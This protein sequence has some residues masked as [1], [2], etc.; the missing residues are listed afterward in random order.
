[1]T[2]ADFVQSR[3]KNGT[4]LLFDGCKSDSPEL[5]F[6]LLHAAIGIVGELHEY[7]QSP[8]QINAHEELGDAL[9]YLVAAELAIGR[10][11]AQFPPLEWDTPG[12]GEGA[13]ILNAAECAAHEL[14]DLCKKYAIYCKPIDVARVWLLL[15]S[16]RGH[17]R[18]LAYR[19][20][21]TLDNLQDTNRAKLEKRYPTG[22][23]NADAQARKD[24]AATH[25]VHHNGAAAF[26]KTA[27]YFAEGKRSDPNWKTDAWRGVVATS[28]DDARKQ[29]EEMHKRGEL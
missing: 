25:Y 21:M 22:Y 11:P 7:R 19:E 27:E 26:V 23:S 20:G 14:L 9:F 28:I 17:L 12:Y 13:V 10:E 5:R 8:T 18:S 4:N 29:C 15:G 2:Y 16:L 1:M 3:F 6:S 24:K